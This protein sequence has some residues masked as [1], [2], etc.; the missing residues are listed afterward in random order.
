MALS[1]FGSNPKICDCRLHRHVRNYV[2]C[3]ELSRTL[4]E[5]MKDSLPLDL[6]AMKKWG[7][8]AHHG[9]S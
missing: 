9:E 1:S 3:L 4:A 2:L 5:Q 8:H 6:K 7:R